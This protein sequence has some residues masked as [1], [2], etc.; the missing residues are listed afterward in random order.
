MKEA[1]MEHGRKVVEAWYLEKAV[2]SKN[3]ANYHQILLQV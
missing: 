2:Y 1:M 3:A